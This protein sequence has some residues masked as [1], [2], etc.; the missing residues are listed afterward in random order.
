MTCRPNHL[1]DIK[2]ILMA[3]D[4]QNV[5]GVLHD[6]QLQA[7]R[8]QV[9]FISFAVLNVVQSTGTKVVSEISGLSRLPLLYYVHNVDLG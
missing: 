9:R 4:L 2:G 1:A 6:M 8:K 5:H 3:F 7:A